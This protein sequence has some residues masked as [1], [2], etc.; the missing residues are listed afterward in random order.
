MSS[1]AKS[2]VSFSVIELEPL[3]HV[4]KLGMSGWFR[5]IYCLRDNCGVTERVSTS[6]RLQVRYVFVSIATIQRLYRTFYQ[7][8]IVFPSPT[9]RSLMQ[10]INS[11]Q[12]LGIFA[13]YLAKCR[14][15][16]IM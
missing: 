4:I 14:K 10:F 13:Q 8:N 2:C 16:A 11:E 7:R 12:Y 5:R 9:T 1:D 6:E 3:K 15:T